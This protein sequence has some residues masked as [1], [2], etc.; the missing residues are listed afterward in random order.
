MMQSP[1]YKIP[2]NMDSISQE[3]LLNIDEVRMQLQTQLEPNSVENLVFD[4]A[5]SADGADHFAL[6][7]NLRS[8]SQYNFEQIKERLRCFTERIRKRLVT[9]TIDESENNQL[10]SHNNF[11]GIEMH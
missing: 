5:G 3:A 1:R 6:M 7:M 11:S 9:N 10:M 2:V 8:I 4:L